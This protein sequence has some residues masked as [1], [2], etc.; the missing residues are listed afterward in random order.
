MYDKIQQVPRGREALPA[1]HRARAR[2]HEQLLRRGRVLQA[3]FLRQQGHRQEGRVHV[4]APHR[5]RPGQSPGLRLHGDLPA[6]SPRAAP[7]SC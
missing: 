7:R 6:G 4:P 3:L 2:G 1:H 5:D